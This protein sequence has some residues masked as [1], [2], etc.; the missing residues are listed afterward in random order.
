MQWKC[1][2]PNGRVF[3][4]VVWNVVNY[5]RAKQSAECGFLRSYSNKNVKKYMYI[6]NRLQKLITVL[7]WSVNFKTGFIVVHGNKTVLQFYHSDPAPSHYMNQWWNVVNWNLRNK[8][9]WNSYRNSYI[10]IQENAFENVVCKMVAILS[11][12]QCVNITIVSAMRS[13]QS[14]KLKWK[15]EPILLA[16]AALLQHG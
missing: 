16:W 7:H 8:L 10:F 1:W 14:G 13:T 11:R 12:H 15:Q 4:S 5:D 2:M 6:L 9:L 3:L